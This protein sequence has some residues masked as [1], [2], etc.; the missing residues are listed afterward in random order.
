MTTFLANW[1]SA[2]FFFSSAAQL[3]IDFGGSF[4]K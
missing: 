2:F 3:A 1:L 4:D